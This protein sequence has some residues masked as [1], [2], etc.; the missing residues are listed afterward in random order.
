MGEKGPCDD[1]D[2]NWRR[3]E[4]GAIIRELEALSEL[5]EDYVRRTGL[6]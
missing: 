2:F 1:Q 5:K 3:D 6:L 4:E